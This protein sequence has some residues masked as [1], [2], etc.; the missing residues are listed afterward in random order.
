VS[1]ELLGFFA[2][3][4]KVERHARESGHPDQVKTKRTWISAFAGMST[5]ESQFVQ[6]LIWFNPNI[7]GN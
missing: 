4:A 2:S 7:N 5:K 1:L 3:G 6:F